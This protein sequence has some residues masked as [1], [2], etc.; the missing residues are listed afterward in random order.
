MA[1][2][3]VYPIVNAGI[4]VGTITNDR[5]ATPIY[6]VSASSN[7]YT[8]TTTT[9]AQ[10]TNL[11]VTIT[12]SGRPAFITLMCTEI[13]PGSNSSTSDGINLTN[14]R[15]AVYFIRNGS[16][17]S[18]NKIGTGTGSE[19]ISAGSFSFFDASPSV[20]SNTYQCYASLDPAGGSGI[21]PSITFYAVSLVAY[22]I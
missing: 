10:V 15:A 20:G 4:A 8:N 2:P 22:E 13:P 11:S 16:Y 19:N 12:S 18:T 3:V 6:S 7:V 14:A 5:L 9:A 17:I 21:S 1:A